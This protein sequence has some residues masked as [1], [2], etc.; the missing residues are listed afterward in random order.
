MRL[1]DDLTF[2]TL[3]WVKHELDE[4]L[5]QAREALEAHAEESGDGEQIRRCAACLHQVQG[6]LRMVELY[7]AALVAEEMEKL[8]EVAASGDLKN[9]DEAYGVLMRGIMQLPDYL[10][11]LQSGHRD[12]PI[13]LLPLLNDLRAAAGGELVAESTLFAPRLDVELPSQV[14]GPEQVLDESEVREKAAKLRRDFQGGLLNWLKG[15]DAGAALQTM[16]DVLD[17]LTGLSTPPQARRLWW[18]AAAVADALSK[19]AISL[20]A[21]MKKLIGRVDREIKRLTDE[22]EHV[23]AA[24]PPDELTRSL[25]YYVAH[26]ENETARLKD[27]SETF[28]LK[29]FMPEEAELE[30]ARGSMA[31]HNRELLNTVAGA[32]REDLLQVK[33]SLDL[34]LRA[35]RDEP[36]QLRPLGETLRR[37]GDTLGMLGLGVPRKRVE[38]NRTILEAM[39]EGQRETDENTLMEVASALLSVEASLDDHIERLGAREESETEGGP[40]TTESGLSRA[41]M[42]RIMYTLLGEAGQNLNRAKEQ[43]VAF[44]EAPWDYANLDECP[45]LLQ[46][47]I[48][49]LRMLELNE[50][51]ELLGGV[52][53]YL[54]QHLIETHGVPSPEE[55]DTLADALESIEYYLG[56]LTDRR[57]GRD[58]ALALARERVSGLGALPQP[59]GPA[60]GEAEP[61]TGQETVEFESLGVVN[62]DEGESGE[63]AG[64]SATEP[65][66]STSDEVDE[67]IREVFVEEVS[68]ELDKLREIYPKW[69]AD[70]DDH[71]TLTVIRRVF[72]TMKGSGRL[73]G[74]LTL[75]EFSWKVENMLNRVLEGN[76]DASKAV[77]GLMDLVVGQAVPQLLAD[78]KGEGAPAL[79]IEGMKATA[80]RI[81]DGEEARFSPAE[82]DET[83]HLEAGEAPGSAQPEMETPPAGHE[84]EREAPEHDRE[85][86]EPEAEHTQE[87]P[88]GETEE[89]GET[90][91]APDETAEREGEPEEPAFE[92]DF[93]L[94]DLHEPEVSDEVA[95]AG[96]REGTG[97]GEAGMDPVLYEIFSKECNAHLL[98]VNAFLSHARPNPARAPITDDLVRSIHTLNGAA[99]MADLEPVHRL[100]DP[101]EVYV[102]RLNAHGMTV[103]REGFQVLERAV[104]AVESIVERAGDDSPEFP[105]VS[106]LAADMEALRDEIP[107]ARLHEEPPPEV[108][109][110]AAPVESAE[111]PGEQPGAGSADEPEQAAEEG[112]ERPGQ[113]A[114]TQDRQPSEDTA[115]EAEAGAEDESRG[116]EEETAPEEEAEPPA[117]VES[118]VDPEL[119]G[120]FLEEGTEI[121][122]QADANMQRWRDKPANTEVVTELQ[123][124]LHTLKGGARM[125]GLN[126]VGDLGHVLESLFEAVADGRV[127]ANEKAF[128][129][130]EAAF[131]R[132]HAD[133]EAAQNGRPTEYPRSMIRDIEALSGRETSPISGFEEADAGE[134]PAEPAKPRVVRFPER[135]ARP[136]TQNR[137]SAAAGH[138]ELVRVRAD[139]LDNLVNYAGE[140]SIYRGRLEQ[141]VTSFRFNLTELEQ[142]VARLREQLRKLEIETEAQILSRLQREGAIDPDDEIALEEFDP[143]E[144]DRFSQLQQYSRALAESVADLVNIDE[145]LTDITRES[146]TLLLQ[147]SRVTS[148]L[149][150]GLMRTR[151][152]PFNSVVPRLRRL[153]RRTSGELGRKARLEVSGAEG[154]MDRT[155]L[156]RMT[157]PLEHMIRNALV[158][159]VEPPG[160]REEKGKPEEGTISIDV[161][162]EASEVVLQVG[163]DGRGIN[164]DAVR[165]IAIKRG[166][167]R[168]D[169]ELTDRDTLGFILE[170]GFSTAEEVS[171]LAGRGVGMD[172]VHAEIKQ[173]SGSLDINSHIGQGT[174]FT[175]RLP[176]T[177]A[178]TQALMVRVG[179]E[180]YA[181]PLSG[182]EGVARVPN[183][184]FQELLQQ[185][186]GASY[187]YAGDD[188]EVQ[189]LSVLLGRE[190]Q[191]PGDQPFVPVLIVRTGDQRAAVRVDELLGSREVVVKS[192]GPQ[193]AAVP[194]I[195]GATILGDGSVILILDLLP[196]VR[197][198][199]ALHL[200]PEEMMAAREEVEEDLRPTI[201]VVDDSI[202]M[203]KVTSRILERHDMQ[204]V[205]AK[206]GVDAVS[207]LQDQV[208]D[209]MLLDIEMPRMDGYELATHMRNDSRLKNIPIIMITSRSGA[210]HRE[211]AEDIGVNRYLGKPYQEA[212]LMSHV[213]ELL[214]AERDAG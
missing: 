3:G 119:L 76:R 80:D 109:D 84:A 63:S 4:T 132:L 202:T 210:K 140:V 138:Q 92:V 200:L 144:L 190:P 150:E 23:F 29:D 152:V 153:V 112:V 117:A 58:Q 6:T 128:K 188:Y 59:E 11:R 22:G 124:D 137:P 175:V 122:D 189:D 107:A 127:K 8:A 141:Q 169:A 79:D 32:I 13:V 15:R 201:M 75:G 162:R 88:A 206:D 86:M 106:E 64:E 126:G 121:L 39:S 208:P 187:R 71:E 66:S 73:V 197:R 203:R 97:T 135:E 209:L 47:V 38:E 14:S 17:E 91:E 27:I 10:D 44:I 41:E 7:G 129:H 196:L 173:L 37:V 57:P 61:T 103:S 166:M 69:K 205:T 108:T 176:F 156:E 213:I 172:V 46:E 214:D 30:H 148:D 34:Y 36:E 43:I 174:Q 155:V 94:S 42:Q 95:D 125:A 81:A 120:V 102:K 12:I 171:K 178:V 115:P 139:L 207:L 45:A 212:D 118:D 186:E 53:N 194:G 181:V 28:R 161:S 168:E 74:A 131:D 77:Y 158:H 142:T 1:E 72:H 48:G 180:S 101:M 21:S 167:L 89:S 55:L 113:A 31:G 163:D 25:L 204:V 5:K 16:R 123:R 33:D 67:E 170:T 151:M 157:A 40:E 18:T 111:P 83:V 96:L 146:E 164:L 133:L 98:V 68:E 147:Q 159:G 160:E 93:G 195:F 211:R 143:L 165:R 52:V 116:A 114:E 149:Q 35:G 99:S 50:P 56:A 154:E 134:E 130:I 199:A 110:E 104:A 183:E 105:D 184:E 54:R 49:A 9:P 193:L 26:A 82:A 70:P 85:S 136:E 191:H 145:I 87:A 182:I 185:G 65:A 177:L 51:A 179:D 2:T 19:E 60:A 62:M 24:E 78:L 90:A 100:T 192:V 20:N 198:G